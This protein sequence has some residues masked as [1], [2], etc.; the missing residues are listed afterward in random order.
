MLGFWGV[1]SKEKWAVSSRE[2]ASEF[3][4]SPALIANPVGC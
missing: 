4:L 1:T 2:I 3:F